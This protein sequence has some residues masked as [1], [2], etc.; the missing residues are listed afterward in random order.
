MYVNDTVLPTLENV[1]RL[2]GKL[3]VFFII[4]V[5]LT[6]NEGYTNNLLKD[7]K[8]SHMQ[9]G[10]DDKNFSIGIAPLEILTPS[11]QNFYVMLVD[12]HTNEK[13]LSGFII[14]GMRFYTE[15]PLGTYKLKY[16]V[17]DEWFGKQYHFGPDTQYYIGDKLFHFTSNG[18]MVS[19]YTVELI[20]QIAGN[21]HRN[22]ISR[23]EFDDSLC[24]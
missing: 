15:I 4:S 10:V 20:L 23:C 5:L 18:R 17:G 13:V 9:H 2:F 22:K 3:F 14:N 6:T 16:A 12:A 11:S 8:K 21:L 19:G 7:D 1:G 24:Y